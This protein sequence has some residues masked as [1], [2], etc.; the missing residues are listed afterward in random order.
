VHVYVLDRGVRTTHS[1]FEGRAIP[2]LESYPNVRS[3]CSP[4]NTTCAADYDGHGTHCAGI[5]AGKD[6]G[7]APKAT[8]HAV[9][10]LSPA[11][12]GDLAGIIDAIDWILVNGEKPAVI[13]MSVGGPKYSEHTWQVA[14]DAVTAGGIVVVVSAGNNNIDACEKAPAFVPSAITVGSTDKSDSR[15]SFSNYGTCIDIFAPGSD[16]LSAGHLDDTDRTIKS[17]TSMACPHVAGAAALILGQNPSLSAYSVTANLISKATPNL[18]TGIPS[19]PS[20]PNKLLY[21]GDEPPTPAP[22]PTTCDECRPDFSKLA[23]NT[24]G[25][26]NTFV[27]YHQTQTLQFERVCSVAGKDLDLRMEIESGYEAKPSKNK[28]GQM[29]VFNVKVATSA[30]VKFTLLHGGQPIEVGKVL[31]SVL[32]LDLGNSGSQWVSTTGLSDSKHG[33]AVL[34]T[35]E[36]GETKFKAMRHGTEADNPTDP[37]KLSPEALSSAVAMVYEATS[38]W[39]V[40]LGVTGEHNSGRNFYIAGSTQLLATTC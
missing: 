11:G 15:S 17:G 40:K 18:I 2:T 22:T 37:A 30:T 13:S 33:N 28:A 31:L 16:V 26:D 4:T 35:S 27:K 7:V 36:Y 32:D 23:Y 1:Q 14:I 10:V 6:Y 8:I 9:A 39:T 19:S 38:Q 12:S 5:V 21:V 25:N 29:Y 34:Q 24:L 20:S 3:V